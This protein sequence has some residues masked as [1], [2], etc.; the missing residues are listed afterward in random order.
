MF[1]ERTIILVRGAAINTYVYLPSV[2]NA[3]AHFLVVSE[4]PRNATGR[5][6]KCTLTVHNIYQRLKSGLGIA[7]SLVI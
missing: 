6:K 7:R 1:I 5:G 3:R 2:T 4:H